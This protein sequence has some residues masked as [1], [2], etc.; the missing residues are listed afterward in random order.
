VIQNG[1]NLA[2]FNNMN[3]KINFLSSLLLNSKE[4]QISFMDFDTVFSS[5]LQ[6]KT[7]TF[8]SG[9]FSD[10]TIILPRIENIAKAFRELLSTIS[11][12][13]IIIIDS[14]NGLMDSLNM[15]NLSKMKK[16]AKTKEGE[17]NGASKHKSAGHQSL[18]ILFLLLKKIEGCKVPIVVTVYQPIE[19]SKK[20][21]QELLSN[22]EGGEGEGAAAAAA[23]A[24]QTN[25][26]VRISNS[27]LFL[28]FI[29]E[30]LKT[31][32]TIIKNGG[33]SSSSSPPSRKS[34]KTFYPYSTWHYYNF[35]DI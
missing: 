23:A 33:S 13:S 16:N 11:C 31:G 2:Y 19:K 6:N 17:S 15:L 28:E 21:I 29:E 25:H 22:T 4:K 27:I 10:L 7:L 20:M 34:V 30:D 12:N 35:I 1:V 18:N 14:L 32:F 24:A 9:D 5:Y 8:D 26:F 3:G